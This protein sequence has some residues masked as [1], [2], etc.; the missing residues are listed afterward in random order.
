MPERIVT[1]AV[2][3]LY[4][5]AAAGILFALAF[6]YRGAQKVDHQASGTSFV[7]RCL[8]F[9]GSVAFWPHLLQRWIHATGE[10]PQEQD[11]HQ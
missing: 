11:A 3:V 10:P 7:F 4:A 2:Y 1:I 5:Y 6:A 8:I 9:P